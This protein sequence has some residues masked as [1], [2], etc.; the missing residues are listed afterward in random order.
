MIG[1][2]GCGN[3]TRSDDGAG[4]AVIRSL[5]ARD[6]A[7]DPRVRLFDAGT[8]GMA[9]IFAARACRRLIIVDACQSGAEAGTIF[10]VPGTELE[11]RYE[12]SLTLHDFRWNHALHAGRQLLGSAFPDSVTVF[13]IEAANVDFGLDLSPLV[14]EGAAAVACRVDALARMVLAETEPAG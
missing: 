12:P 6:I 10:E 1:I 2:V 14:A 7:N 11:R 3:A 4:P 5:T 9:V 8:D 13:L